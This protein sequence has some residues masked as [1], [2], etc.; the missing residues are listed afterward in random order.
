VV[1]AAARGRNPRQDRVVTSRAPLDASV[2]IPARNS[3]SSIGAQLA[4]LAA[5]DFAGRWEVVVA[6][7]GSTDA[8]AAIVT[9]ATN[10]FPVPLRVL[11]S[12]RRRGANAARNDGIRATAAPAV[13]FCDSDDVV[14]PAWVRSLVDAL[15]AAHT[16]GGPLEFAAL[17]DPATRALAFDVPSSVQ[18]YCGFRYALSANLGVRREVFDRVGAFDERFAHGFDEVDFGYRVHL[19]A[20]SLQESPGALVHYRLRADRRALVRQ[21]FFYGIGSRIFHQKFPELGDPAHD[22]LAARLAAVARQ[23]ARL[24]L[25]ALGRRDRFD[26]RLAQLAY[27]LGALRGAGGVPSAPPGPPA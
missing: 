20:L 8:T 6:D 14:G 10:G 9:A 11:D 21:Q 16:A 18:E 4:A 25:S 13:L 7:N 17:N 24:P 19:A 27:E 15:G 1:T 22:R 2:V 26:R 5:Q 12:S 3:A 23:A